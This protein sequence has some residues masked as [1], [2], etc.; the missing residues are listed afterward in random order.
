[1]LAL[2]RANAGGVL[3]KINP[4]GRSWSAYYRTVV[5]SEI[6][7]ALDNHMWKLAYKWAKH[8]HP[9]KSKLGIRQVLR[10][11]QQGQEGPVGVRRPRQRCLPA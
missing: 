5:S 1:M 8:S 7:T 3:K 2:R 9:N 4:I 10:P 11:V 6:F